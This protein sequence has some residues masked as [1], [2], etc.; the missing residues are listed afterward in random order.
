MGRYLTAMRREWDNTRPVK[1]LGPVEIAMTLGGI[2]HDT[3][4]NYSAAAH[5]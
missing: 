2:N 1:N 5:A 3:S 4:F